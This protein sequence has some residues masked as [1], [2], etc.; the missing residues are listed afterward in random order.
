[1]KIYTDGSA[2]SVPQKAWGS[3]AYLL[4]NE[5]EIVACGGLGGTN[6][7]AELKAIKE[8]LNW[9][10]ENIEEPKE[11]LII[12]DSHYAVNC[13]STW[14]ESWERKQRDETNTS[15][16]IMIKKSWDLKDELE[17]KGINVKFKKI[18][19]HGKD[20]DMEEVDI[21]GNDMADLIAT[22]MSAYYS[23]KI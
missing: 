22:R 2:I 10:I 23:G 15:H 16:F 4:N 17:T 3:G 7:Y 5:E 20:P 8:T 14:R 9:L 1:M 11:V 6:Q 21:Q 12:S 19:G 18:R 13:I